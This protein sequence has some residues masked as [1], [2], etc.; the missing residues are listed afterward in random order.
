MSSDDSASAGEPSGDKN[1]RA[2]T[3]V[4]TMGLRNLVRD[5]YLTAS[6]NPAVLSILRF[7]SRKGDKQQRDQISVAAFV[8]LRIGG[9]DS[10]KQDMIEFQSL[11]A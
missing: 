9:Q 10:R 8:S 1:R 4:S 7:W 6:G 5:F 2:G 3:K 11:G